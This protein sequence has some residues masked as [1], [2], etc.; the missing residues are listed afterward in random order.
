[1]SREMRDRVTVDLRGAGAHVRERAAARGVSVAVFVRRVVLAATEQPPDGG[2]EEVD[3]VKT[4]PRIKVTVRLPAAHAVMLARRA[5]A[6]DVSQGTY[7]AGLIGGVPPPVAVDRREAMAVL[8]RS[9]DQLAVISTDLNT[10]MRLL[11]QGESAQLE[12]YRA[13]V[14]SLSDDVRRH[15][16]VACRF[17]S[18]VSGSTSHRPRV[19]SVSRRT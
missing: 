1:M 17:L 9:T 13:G 4:G 2:R 5:R 18:D 10:F 12:A 19:R 6:A 7:I 14:M 3:G 16:T 15:L 8:L 11:R